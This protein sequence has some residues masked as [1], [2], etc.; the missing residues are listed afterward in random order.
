METEDETDRLNEAIACLE[1]ALK[2]KDELIRNQNEMIG[3]LE[4]YNAELKEMLERFLDF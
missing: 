3:E 4:K 2:A 1:A